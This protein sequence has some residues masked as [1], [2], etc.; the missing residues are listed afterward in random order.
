MTEQRKALEKLITQVD[1]IVITGH[2]R[3]DEDS[4]SSCLG[5]LYWVRKHFPEKNSRVVYSGPPSK[6]YDHHNLSS[7]IG[8]SETYEENIQEGDLLIF[9]DGTP[10]DRFF[11]EPEKYNISNYKTF[12]MDHHEFT[13]EENVY[14][15]HYCEPDAASCAELVSKYIFSDE[16]LKD[17]TIATT[18][19]AGILR[20]S[21]YFKYVTAKN[22]DV[23][24]EAKRIVDNS[25]LRLK[26]LS[27]RLRAVTLPEF[28]VMNIIADSSASVKLDGKPNLLYSYVS[29]E[30][31]TKFGVG[32]VSS[33]YHV[34]IS[35]YNGVV[36]DYPWG[37]MIIDE[38]TQY[39]LSFRSSKGG[40]NVAELAKALFGGGGHAESA[41]AVLPIDSA[42]SA[43]DACKNVV[44]AVKNA[45][46]EII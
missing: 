36:E 22:T 28:E 17:E 13:P 39:K 25:N 2:M 34:F 41:G 5:M 21:G 23:F 43:E 1:N 7:E 6:R 40:P 24:L 18:L 12:C 16:D 14:D 31:R 15:Y 27:N 8:W 42:E 44:E 38:G 32:P 37:F 30:V 35:N 10:M 11:S 3:P 9:L 19:M 33:A 45:E 29:K 20:D 4:I 26:E 46:F